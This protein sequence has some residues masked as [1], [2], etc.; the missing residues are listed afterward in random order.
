M[1]KRTIQQ[2]LIA[3]L[4]AR[5]S[6]EVSKS[7]RGVVKLTHH[8]TPNVYYFVGSA[9]SLRRGR[10]FATSR[11]MDALKARLLEGL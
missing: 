10:S 6:A 3:G 7:G 11:T 5:G 1:P 2:K 9:G 4:V 8:E